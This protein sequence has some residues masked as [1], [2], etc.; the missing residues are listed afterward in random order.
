LA[1]VGA[2]TKSAVRWWS[3]WEVVDQILTKYEIVKQVVLMDADFCPAL[4]MR[5]RK[6]LESQ[7]AQLQLELSIVVDSGLALVKATYE[8]EGD[9]FLS[10][11]VS[12]TLDALELHAASVLAERNIPIHAPNVVAIADRLSKHN[13]AQ[14]TALIV[15]TIAKAKPVFNYWRQQCQEGG[16]LFN[17]LRVFKGCTMFDPVYISTAS[18]DILD[19]LIPELQS[20]PIFQS[21]TLYR[22][23]RQEFPHYKAAATSIDAHVD[24]AHWWRLHA[25]TLPHFASAAKRA[26]VIQPSSAAAERVFSMLGNM[27][28]DRQMRAL[29][30]YKSVAVMMRFNDM[31]RAKT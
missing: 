10:A 17:I 12:P 16:K 30:D 11:R 8:L 6:I 9:A 4:R 15:Q 2:K 31:Q 26:I 28:D 23:V 20:H 25:S 7:E 24:I 27:F 5:M 14:S 19:Q 29:A 21:G 1:E 13:V 22:D 18:M 3:E